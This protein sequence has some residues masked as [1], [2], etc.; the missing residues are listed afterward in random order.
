MTCL[1]GRM[2][3]HEWQWVV[4]RDESGGQGYAISW[5]GLTMT[6]GEIDGDLQ[7]AFGPPLSKGAEYT[8]RVRLANYEHRE[9]LHAFGVHESGKAEFLRGFDLEGGS[10]YR[11]ASDDVGP[12]RALITSGVTTGFEF[13]I[14]CDLKTSTSEGRLM[15][16]AGA[17]DAME[18][19]PMPQGQVRFRAYLFGRGSSVTVVI[20]PGRPGGL[21]AV[22]ERGGRIA[23]SSINSRLAVRARHLAE[24]LSDVTF[25]LDGGERVPAFGSYLQLSEVLEAQLGGCMKESRTREIQLRDVQHDVLLGTLDYLYTRG[26][27]RILDTLA[28]MVHGG[29]DCVAGMVH[30]L[31][32]LAA[33]WQLPEL[34][35]WCSGALVDLLTSATVVGTLLLA[36]AHDDLALESAALQ[37]LV[38]NAHEVD[39]SS[40]RDLIK[41]NP[42]LALG[43]IRAQGAKRQRRE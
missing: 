23:S 32:Q 42:D 9:W 3:S 15:F 11:S 34:L 36:H 19:F 37:F 31:Y 18:T 24:K 12:G 40:L 4:D 1:E 39:D 6:N 22:L 25:V 33:R 16:S 21:A 8:L 5:D 2:A 26:I 43:V 28:Q 10:F 38:D 35:Q 13:V 7:A 17:A 30:G 27:D 20:H 41:G 14:R 29:E